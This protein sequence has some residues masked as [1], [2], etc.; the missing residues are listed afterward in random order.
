MVVAVRRL[1]MVIFMETGNCTFRMV[2]VLRARSKKACEQGRVKFFSRPVS[3][4]RA[5]L[6]RTKCM[7][8]GSGP[9]HAGV[10]LTKSVSAFGTRWF[11]MFFACGLTYSLTF[12]GIAL[13]KPF[14][15]I[16]CRT[17]GNHQRWLGYAVSKLVTT[18]FCDRFRADNPDSFK[19]MYAQ[20]VA[21]K[22]PD[23]PTGVDG[24]DERVSEIL[25]K[26]MLEQG[27]LAQKLMLQKTQA[28]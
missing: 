17:K 23:L 5:I 20:F 14:D 8:G 27:P 25:S 6:K 4:S 12:M 16:S 1:G 21:E 24:T 9:S 7:A 3:G 13:N 22:I 19:G 26:I 18:E 28:E 11:F 2:I 10:D 15:S